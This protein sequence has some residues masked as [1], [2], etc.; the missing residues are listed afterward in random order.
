MIFQAEGVSPS[1]SKSTPVA[2]NLRSTNAWTSDHNNDIDDT[3]NSNERND[4][5][6]IAI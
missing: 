6:G 4:V 1:L 5:N 2:P 3:T